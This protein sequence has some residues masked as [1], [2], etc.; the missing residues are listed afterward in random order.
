MDKEG[1][2]SVTLTAGCEKKT[3]HGMSFKRQ[4][5]KQAH[6][7]GTV[8][9]PSLCKKESLVNQPQWACPESNRGDDQGAPHQPLLPP[10]SGGLHA[11]EAP[12][13]KVWA[14]LPPSEKNDLRIHQHTK[15]TDDGVINFSLRR[16]SNAPTKCGVNTPRTQG[17]SQSLRQGSNLRPAAYKTAALPIE[18]LRQTFISA[19]HVP[20]PW[21]AARPV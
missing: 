4:P 20:S 14:Y 11:Q 17:G 13:P 9:L 21:F 15:Q 2:G 5:G 18:L 12:S 19:P 16:R 3:G 10:S 1:V 6:K 8:T 7:K